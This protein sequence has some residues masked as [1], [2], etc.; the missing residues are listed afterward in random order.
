[1]AYGNDFRSQIER[2]NRVTVIETGHH[3]FHHRQKRERFTP[4]SGIVLISQKQ[5]INQLHCLYRLIVKITW[6]AKTKTFRSDMATDCCLRWTTYFRSVQT[7]LPARLALRRCCSCPVSFLGDQSEILLIHS[8]KNTPLI[9]PHRLSHF[10]FPQF[11]KAMF[12]PDDKW[13]YVP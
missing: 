13:E 2:K 9:P 10:L 1:M 4:W 6:R 5:N 7:G 8:P 3:P 11:I 12:T